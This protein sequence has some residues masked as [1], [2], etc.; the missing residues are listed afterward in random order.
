MAIPCR[1]YAGSE[2]R[3]I[4]G[5]RKGTTIVAPSGSHTRPTADRVREAIFSILGDVQGL[6]VLDLFAGSGAL[7]LEALSRGAANAD[8]VDNR[9]AAVRAMNRNLEKLDFE[10]A[11]IFKRDYL[12][13]LK[14]AARKGKRYDLIFID[15]PYRIHRAIEPELGNRLPEVTARGG[16]IIVESSSREDICL[17]FDLVVDKLYGDTRVS[18]YV[19]P[20]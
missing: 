20:S 3:I 18:I 10:K 12:V 14:D 1:P 6:M 8:M 15:P 4:A 7:A 5:M 19:P 13:F 16:R 2:M 9:L 11:A 17:P